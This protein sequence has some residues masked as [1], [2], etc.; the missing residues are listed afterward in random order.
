MADKIAGIYVEVGSDGVQKANERLAGMGPAGAKAEQAADKVKQKFAETDAV[1]TKLEQS[2]SE[3][4][5][6]FSGKLVAGLAGTFASMSAVHKVIGETTEFD[7]L[8][9]R[10][11]GVTD[12]ADEARAKFDELE[13]QSD[14]MMFTENQLAEA[15]IHMTQMGLEPA[16]EDLLGFANIASDTG[17]TV[18]G[19]ANTVVDASMGMYRGLRQ[20]G[21]KAKENGDM[22]DLTFKGTTTTVEKSSTAIMKYMVDIG[23]NQFAGAAARQLDTMGG[24]VKTLEDA[25]GDLFREI[26]RN[27][28][29]EFISTGMREA[30]KAVNLVTSAVEAL[31]FTMSKKPKF[32]GMSAALAEWTK[33]ATRFDNN[34]LTDEEQAKDD[35]IRRILGDIEKGSTSQSD[36]DLADYL[37]KRETLLDALAN[38]YNFSTAALEELDRQYA[39]KVNAGKSVD[40]KDY[41]PKIYQGKDAVIGAAADPGQY[42][43]IKEG[44]LTEREKAQRDYEDK[45]AFLQAFA[46][47]DTATMEKLEKNWADYLATKYKE[48]YDAKRQKEKEVDSLY[49]GYRTEYE[50]LL[51]EQEKQRQAI[52]DSTNLTEEQRAE[53]ILKWR[54]KSLSEQTQFALAQEQEILQSSVTIF[55]GLAGVAKNFGGEQSRV[56][57]G[58]FALS[59][60]FSIAQATMSIATGTAKALELGWPAGIAAGF[61]VAAQGA[62]LLAQITNAKWYAGSYAEGGQVG[63]R[64]GF[65]GVVGEHGPEIAYQGTTIVSR[66]DTINM[67]HE[68]RAPQ[69]PQ[70]APRIT[71]V[72]VQQS[73]ANAYESYMGSARGHRAFLNFLSENRT[74]IRSLLS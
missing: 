44:L 4:S 74:E 48:D 55:E 42:A 72:N 2:T 41:D 37:S 28:V 5:N 66:Q 50:Q 14:G 71:V 56:Y 70:Q 8:V 7:S 13:E 73:H 39:A 68:S 6:V 54:K 31:F 67:L 29:G 63:S 62:G 9:Q 27:A 10:L 16:K 57:Q 46:E 64:G 47:D 32:E 34:K 40:K 43:S 60:G 26:G 15:F 35:A 61:Q 1:A 65:L 3:L 12:S 18:E 38:G 30:A 58:L 45:K 51:V 59:R 53:L 11:R 22:L 69:A 24:S 36:K 23:N 20:F 17:G 49:A 25:W 52:M 33:N 19:L 21:V